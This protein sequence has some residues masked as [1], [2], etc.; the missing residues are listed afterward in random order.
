MYARRNVDIHA[1][2]LILELRV[3]EGIHQPGRTHRAHTDPRLEA[4]RGDG[5][6]VADL[7][8]GLL[9]IC[10]SQLR[11]LNDSRGCICKNRVGRK[12]RERHL[13]IV[14]VQMGQCVQRR[15]LCSGAGLVAFMA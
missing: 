3:D 14:A 2:I 5:Y 15:I 12:V 11:V 6:A 13:V 10:G 8:L 1:D 7:Q 9:T 4:S